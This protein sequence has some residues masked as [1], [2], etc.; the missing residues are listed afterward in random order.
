MPHS[1]QY[2]L[3]RSH[4][5]S[6]ELPELLV[7]LSSFVELDSTEEFCLGPQIDGAQIDPGVSASD[8]D[9][10]RRAPSKTDQFIVV[11]DRNDDANIG[12]VASPGVGVVVDD[13]IS[14]LEI[15]I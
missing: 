12:G 14:I 1:T 11:E 8:V 7:S 3:R 5:I 10:M 6:D 2:V 9:P 4:I 15:S 13:D